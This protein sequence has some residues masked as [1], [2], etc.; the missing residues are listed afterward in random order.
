MRFA[1]TSLVLA[2][3][4]LAASCVEMQR[5]PGMMFA[6]AP[7]GARV[8]VDGVDTGF[9][10][11]CHVD[12]ERAP[13]DIDLVLEG[14][15]PASVHSEKGGENWLIH[16]DE[17]WINESNW[18]FPLWLNARDGLFPVKLEM[19]YDPARVF[20]RLRLIEGQDRPRRGGG[21]DASG[22]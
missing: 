1:S 21:R 22:R 12:L 5:T 11:P 8:V 18:R 20:V 16:W 10:T 19:T 17:A 9:V 7:A 6:T 15:R 4:P 3:A 2:L 14:F 13:H